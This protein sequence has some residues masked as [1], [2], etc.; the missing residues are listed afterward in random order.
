MK[1]G[2]LFWITCKPLKQLRKAGLLQLIQNSAP[3]VASLYEAR[4]GYMPL[5]LKTNKTCLGLNLLYMYLE[6]LPYILCSLGLYCNFD[7]NK[8]C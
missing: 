6:D 8:T 1:Q 4:R 5:W 3:S 2:H 7:L